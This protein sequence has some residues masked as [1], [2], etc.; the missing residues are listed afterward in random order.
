M[1]LKSITLGRS[2]RFLSVLTYGVTFG[3]LFSSGAA[4]GD[5][6]LKG[7]VDTTRQ[8]A[9][10]T[11]SQRA[12]NVSHYYD[13]H[14]KIIY[15]F[16]PVAHFRILDLLNKSGDPAILS[17]EDRAIINSFQGA[18]NAA[19]KIVVEMVKGLYDNATTPDLTNFSAEAKARIADIRARLRSG[20]LT[21]E[22]VESLLNK[23]T[24]LN[25]KDHNGKDAVPEINMAERNAVESLQKQDNTT[26][27]QQLTLFQTSLRDNYEILH[28]ENLRHYWT[29]AAASAVVAAATVTIP[30]SIIEKIPAQWQ[31]LAK[32][33]ITFVLI[34]RPWVYSRTEAFIRPGEAVP[35]Q[36]VKVQWENAFKLMWNVD[37]TGM[38]GTVDPKVNL[39]RI[40]TGLM[41][42]EINDLKNLWGAF[43][44][45]SGNI[46][47]PSQW[48]IPGSA[49]YK[50]GY[51]LN[52]PFNV[53]QVGLN[54]FQS[55]VQS[56]QQGSEFNLSGFSGNAFVLVG[57]QKGIELTH[58]GS[59]PH[60]IAGAITNPIPALNSGFSID[61]S[62]DLSGPLGGN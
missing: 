32:E 13:A 41:F 27:Q 57:L 12:F 53:F 62:G 33:T 26:L 45:I 23:E 51:I 34:R 24:S 59:K 39:V 52:T 9:Q 8:A 48:N 3:A 30:P 56:F 10:L 38:V 20:Q 44:G 4:W 54:V 36:T 17:N 29:S 42:G 7:T 22:Q 18:Q 60:L 37:K 47:L 40:S 15:D 19:K 28:D 5:T 16:R 14:S 61:A 43:G 49:N 25:P 46:R 55:L 50:V 21:E 2:G 11:A 31:N 35:R 6:V 58:I 1:S